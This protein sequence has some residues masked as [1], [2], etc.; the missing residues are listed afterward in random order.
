M[1]HINST[2]FF[3]FNQLNITRNKSRPSVQAKLEEPIVRGEKGTAFFYDHEPSNNS[4][5][6][7][8][9]IAK[10]NGK[11][12][13][14]IPCDD[15]FKVEVHREV[16]R[17]Y[18]KVSYDSLSE[19][20]KDLS[21]KFI[22]DARYNKAGFSTFCLELFQSGDGFYPNVIKAYSGDYTPPCDNEPEPPKCKV[23][24]CEE[25]AYYGDLCVEH[26]ELST[27]IDPRDEEGFRHNLYKQNNL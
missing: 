17:L 14:L 8:S 16:D 7:I 4:L 6:L 11:D 2:A 23:I 26:E 27:P 9:D 5:S 21:D 1:K 19:L 12:V 10:E 22:E 18:N 13:Y 25:D 24:G 3:N 15:K 20:S